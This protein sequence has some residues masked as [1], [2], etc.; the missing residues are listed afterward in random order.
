MK[1]MKKIIISVLALFAFGA[2]MM[3]Q[4]LDPTVEVSR[5]YEGKLIEVHKPALEMSVPDTLHKFDLGFDY[6]VFDNPYKGSYDFKP[7]VME[8]R[9][10]SVQRH[11][12]T[13]F[14]QAG[15]GY[16]VHPTL[17]LLWSPI[18]KGAFSMD[19]Y[20][21]HRSYIGEYRAIEQIPAW[22]GY[23]LM[24]KAGID[25]GYDWQKAD[26]DFGA[27][28]FGIADKD[29]RRDRMFN[30][31]DA[32]V[33]L[34]SKSLWSKKFIYNVDLAYRFAEDAAVSKM[35]IH[36]L[37]LD[38][39]FGQGSKKSSRILF[40]LGMDMSAYSGALES[41]AARF[42][43][44]PHYVYTKGI[45]S[46]DLGVRVS[47]VK[48]SRDAFGN[49]NQIVYPDVR[50]D[51]ALVPDA[52]KM[53]LNVGGGDKLQTYSSLIE[54][55]HHI[56]LSYG[57]AGNGSLMGVTVE[58]VSAV[59]G[60]E[61][62]VS[63]HFSY[64]LRTGYVNYKS[65]PLDAVGSVGCQYVPMLGYSP[66]Q[67]AFT[68]LDWNMAFQSVR[69][70]GSVV[71]NLAWG[72]ENADFIG[73]SAVEGD[74]AFAYS[75][76]SRINAGVDCNF[77]SGRSSAAGFKVPGYADLGVFGEYVFNRK[78]SLWLR[79]GNLLNMEIQRNLLF[80]EK[81]INFTAGICLNL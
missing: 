56:D 35:N 77:A 36:D 75:W 51:L 47:V 72:I 25:F 5:V 53:Y 59:L 57:L 64:N 52:L 27:S 67:K 63:S 45:L 21:N 38:A 22:D 20:A 12:N 8:M 28:Y 62:R 71:Y 42:Y 68:A 39:S 48:A 6:W 78:I 46:L 66:Y 54:K 18:K 73:L 7:Y 15:A 61:G 14:L 80:A 17:D 55:N 81:G 4:N 70:D 79:G 11:K 34:K 33:S 60:F 40:D 37:R 30:A 43:V 74:A 19:V 50:M 44:V 29:Y 16:T 2:A 23:D 32:Y 1:F 10:S 76:N 65:A 9:P 13:F 24:S 41:S 49:M 31:V 26:F 69:F 3:G 58:R